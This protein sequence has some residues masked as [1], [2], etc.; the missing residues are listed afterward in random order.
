[1]K[2]HAGEGKERKGASGD[3]LKG[4]KP[5]GKRSSM[6]EVAYKALRSAI[7]N[8][9]LKPGQRL[10]EQKL[11]DKMQVS[12]V[13]V[14]EAIK[15]LEQYGFVQR[16]PVR[17]II[18]KKVSEEDVYEAFGIRA[19]L[20]S[21]AACQATERVDKEMIAALETIL[22]TARKAVEDG[23]LEKLMEL[24]AQFH[25]MVYK[26]A[27]S[28]MLYRLIS[29]FL[30]FVARYHKPLLNSV[31][32]ASASIEGHRAMVDA[33]RRGDTEEVERIVKAHILEGRDIILKEMRSGTLD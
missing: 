8:G 14:R 12:R 24:N 19:A 25:E 5:V 6:A 28:E 3:F 15:K 11:S 21:Y 16:L 1:M 31:S 26:A 22:D 29:A 2:E 27:K 4:I 18:V 7:V 13:P 30:D 23:K 9:D 17:G 32:R 33:M 20:E 10:V